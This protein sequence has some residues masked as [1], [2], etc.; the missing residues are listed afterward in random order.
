MAPRAK[1]PWLILGLLSQGPR[2]GYDIQRE[3][4]EATVH[5]WRESF[6]AIY[7]ALARLV[8]E[9]LV[10]AVATP[11]NA[12][13]RKAY[14]LTANGRRSLQAW[15]EQPPEIEVGRNEL[16][17]KLYVGETLA[18]DVLAGHIQSAAQRHAEVLDYL[19]FAERALDG[20]PRVRAYRLLAIRA[21]QRLA[22]ARLQWAEDA[23][24]VLSK[25][26]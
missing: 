18:P 15:L 10:R 3:V 11:A 6:G 25:L 16:M 20:S 26:R 14:A 19:N 4:D 8:R 2:S 5:F 22:E 7:P 21:G 13:G 17:L 24:R 1:S 9:G 12:R 23:L